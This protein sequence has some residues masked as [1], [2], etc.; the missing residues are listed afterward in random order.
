MKKKFSDRKYRFRELGNKT[1]DKCPGKRDREL[2]DGLIVGPM[3]LTLRSLLRS[4]V[5][6][7]I[8]LHFCVDASSDSDAT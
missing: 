5:G 4:P 6:L 2:A 7:L 8:R 1:I 3:T